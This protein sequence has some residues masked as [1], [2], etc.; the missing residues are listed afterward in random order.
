MNTLERTSPKLT[1]RPG[2][3]HF[4]GSALLYMLISMRGPVVE[5]AKRGI[6]D[7]W[8]SVFMMASNLNNV[9]LSLLD[10]SMFPFSDRP[11]PL[12]LSAWGWFEH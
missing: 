5:Y 7:A 11:A 4:F 2:C 8:F 10:D 3:W 1:S 9:G 12:M 6:S